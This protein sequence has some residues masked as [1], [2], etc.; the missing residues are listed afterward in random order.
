M[1]PFINKLTVLVLST[2]E[3]ADYAEVFALSRFRWSLVLATT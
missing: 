3:S 2:K 1:R